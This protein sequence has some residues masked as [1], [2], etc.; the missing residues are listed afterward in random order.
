M[1]NKNAAYLQQI[2]ISR[3]KTC[4]KKKRE[5]SFNYNWI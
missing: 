5:N 1:T 3:R 4:K 2:N